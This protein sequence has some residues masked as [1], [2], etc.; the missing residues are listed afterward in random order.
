MPVLRSSST[1]ADWAEGESFVDKGSCPLRVTGIAV[2]LAERTVGP[3][4]TGDGSRRCLASEA[5][6]KVPVA[7][8]SRME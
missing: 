8:E 6:T 7:P 3:S 4:V 5:V 2:P 1:K